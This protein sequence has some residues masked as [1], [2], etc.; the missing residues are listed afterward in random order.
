MQSTHW[1]VFILKRW[2]VIQQER[3]KFCATYEGINACPA[4]GI[5]M[6]DMTFQALEAFKVGEGEKPRPRGKINSKKEDKRD[7]ALITLIA[8]V[9][10]MKTKKDS[11]KEKRVQYMEE[12]MNA[13]MEIQRRRVEMEA[14][15]QAKLPEM[16]AG[17]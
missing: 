6:Q 11:R 3:N 7:V 1:W 17:K 13:F 14:E 9:K 8:T 5:S 16:E 2:K 15:K 4:S 10:G 12:Q